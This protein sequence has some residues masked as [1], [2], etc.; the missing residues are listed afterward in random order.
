MSEILRLEF[1]AEVVTKQ[2]TEW[3][4]SYFKDI[5]NSP[6]VIGISGR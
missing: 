3:I 1:N 6:S 4:S 2:I 5:P